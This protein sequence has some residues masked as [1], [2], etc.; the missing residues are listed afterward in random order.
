[1]TWLGR[2]RVPILVIIGA[3]FLVRLAWLLHADPVPVSDFHNYRT[4]ALDI[5]DHR[6]FGYP[7]PTS[8]FLPLHPL[9]LSV[10][11]F[12]SRS[13][14]WLGFSM[15]VL[16]TVSIAL[17]YLGAI[18]ILGTRRAALVAAGVFAFFPTFVA[19]SPVLATEHLFIVL[20]LGAVA[21]VTRLDEAPHLYAVVAGLLV[22]G[23]I[24]TRGEAVFYV[25]ATLFF[26]WLGG[27]LTN[28]RE[29]VVVSA[30]VMAAS[31][32]WWFRGTYATPWL[33]TRPAACR[34]A[35]D[36]TSTSPTTT[37]AIMGTSATSTG[38]RRTR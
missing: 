5:L 21:A 37:P 17:I 27:K 2:E 18:K 10:F 16:G 8:F 15:V 12:F 38:P 36:S 30:L 32:F 3:G 6:Q 20:M 25:P 1:M 35:R 24:L 31:S 23:A 9:Y 7:E 13:D 29:R 4:L 26:I 22:G 14:V 28:T 33:W 19:F 34:Q 11:A